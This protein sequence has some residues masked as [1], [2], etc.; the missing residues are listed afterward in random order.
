[1]GSTNDD[2]SL[3]LLN[4]EVS[5]TCYFCNEKFDNV[6]TV[7]KHIE[8][9]HL[10]SSIT[11]EFTISTKS[12]MS[13]NENLKILNSN[14]N[15]KSFDYNMNRLSS[16]QNKNSA[17]DKRVLVDISKNDDKSKYFVIEKDK[18]SNDTVHENICKICNKIL[19]SKKRIY[20]HMK[21]VHSNITILCPDCNKQFSNKWYLHRHRYRIHSNNKSV[22]CLQCKKYFS[23]DRYLQYHKNH[24]H[25]T[26][27]LICE[28]CGKMFTHTKYLRRHV[29][30]EHGSASR[31]PCPN[32]KKT[33][34]YLS[35][36]LKVCTL[37][38]SKCHIC[39]KKIK[40]VQLH[41]RNRHREIYNA[42]EVESS[43]IKIEKFEQNVE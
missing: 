33:P 21:R 29:S 36:H 40:H 30:L 39:N 22:M 12:H 4:N 16:K 38:K 32:C 26:A 14:E 6:D 15:I 8:V 3:E 10:G 24:V 2:E 37:L 23:N 19:K 35:E 25:T 28:H 41:I 31:Q 42:G 13:K 11:H 17:K 34:K 1:M 27:S 43:N 9:N 7:K 5:A 20:E 18:A